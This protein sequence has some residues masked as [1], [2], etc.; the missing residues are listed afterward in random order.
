MALAGAIAGLAGS[1]Y[2]LGAKGH[3]EEGLGTG[4]GFVGIAVALLCGLR[5]LGVLVAGVV[6]GALGQG[7][8]AVNAIVPADTLALAQ[9]ASILAV[10]AVAGHLRATSSHGGA[11]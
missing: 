9:A 6:F 10:A 2:V 5:A 1:H 4:V 7:G 11:R 3:A 8:L